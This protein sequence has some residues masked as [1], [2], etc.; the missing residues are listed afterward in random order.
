[1]PNK[2]E[3]ATEIFLKKILGSKRGLIRRET[4]KANQVA[5]FDE[6]MSWLVLGQG[7]GA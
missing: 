6:E 7:L 2:N 5:E 3:S 4:V 1:L